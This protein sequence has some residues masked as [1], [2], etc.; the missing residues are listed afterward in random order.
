MRHRRCPG[1]LM[2]PQR[3]EVVSARKPSRPESPSTVSSPPRTS[4]QAPTLP[5]PGKRLETP[6]ELCLSWQKA[7]QG[8]KGHKAGQPDTGCEGQW[9]QDPLVP[10]GPTEGLPGTEHWAGLRDFEGHRTESLPLVQAWSLEGSKQAAPWSGWGHPCAPGNN[11]AEPG[12]LPETTPT[13]C[14]LGWEGASHILAPGWKGSWAGLGDE[15]SPRSGWFLRGRALT[16]RVLGRGSPSYAWHNLFCL[17]GTHVLTPCFQYP[18]LRR[19]LSGRQ[20]AKK[21]SKAGSVC[22]SD[23]FGHFF[24]LDAKNTG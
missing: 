13:P 1:D 21:L 7:A 14:S 19:H 15:G 23:N 12:V 6:Q 3:M 10:Q 4:S 18:V 16:V 24:P 2:A 17:T 9:P 8:V 20:P 22:L 5:T 11:M